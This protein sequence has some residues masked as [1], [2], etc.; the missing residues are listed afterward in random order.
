MAFS[1]HDWLKTA[2]TNLLSWF[3][4]EEQKLAS[5]LYPIFQDAKKLVEKDLLSDVISGIPV[6]TAALKDGPEAA[7]KA[8][9]DHIVPLIKAQG[10]ELASTTLNTLANALVAQAQAALTSTAHTAD[11]LSGA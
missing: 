3:G 5:F 8:A 2:W 7:L 11:T 1:F 4:V 9:E 10:A 6:V